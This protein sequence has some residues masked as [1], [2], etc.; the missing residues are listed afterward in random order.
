MINPAITDPIATL[1][2]AWS[3]GLG[4]ASVFFRIVVSVVLSAIIGCERSS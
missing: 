2:G 4:T 3:T 1:L